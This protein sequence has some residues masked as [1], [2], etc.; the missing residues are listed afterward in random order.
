MHFSFKLGVTITFYPTLQGTSSLIENTYDFSYCCEQ[1]KLQCVAQVEDFATYNS[2]PSLTELMILHVDKNRTD[3][4]PMC[5]VANELHIMTAE[6]DTFELQFLYVK[7]H[8]YNLK[9]VFF[10]YCFSTFFCSK[11]T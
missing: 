7:L 2:P 6:F 4:L 1:E 8:A 10:L 5:S 9:T 11:V 3:N